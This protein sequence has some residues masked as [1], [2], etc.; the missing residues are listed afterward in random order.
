MGKEEIK[1]RAR[2]LEKLSESVGGKKYY[3]SLIEE[4]TE[5]GYKE[6][7]V[8][9]AFSELREQGLVEFFYLPEGTKAMLTER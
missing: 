3:L 1:A 6:Q 9:V 5:D 8:R 2:I 4:M 7:E